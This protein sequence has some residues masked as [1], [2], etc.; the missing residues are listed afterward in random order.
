MKL[1]FLKC[2]VCQTSYCP[3]SNIEDIHVLKMCA[4][5][6]V[7]KCGDSSG[8]D[9]ECDNCLPLEEMVILTS[10]LCCHLPLKIPERKKFLELKC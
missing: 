1:S 4:S 5:V 7:R 9:Q 8:F 6:K 2:K 10:S 3:Y